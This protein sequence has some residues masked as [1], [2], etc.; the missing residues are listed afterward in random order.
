[1]KDAN[2]RIQVTLVAHFASNDFRYRA[3]FNMINFTSGNDYHHHKASF[4]FRI[5]L[6]IFVPIK[7]SVSFL[8][9]YIF[10]FFFLN[11]DTAI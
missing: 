7:I 6:L 8:L 4:E 11:V 10:I 5:N 1:M 9:F 3:S 2:A